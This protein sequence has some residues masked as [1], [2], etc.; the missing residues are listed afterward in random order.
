V[1]EQ[2]PNRKFVA[3]FEVHTYSSLNPT[4]MQRYQGT[5]NPADA[6]CVLYDPHVFELKRMEV[7][8]K[9]TIEQRFG[10]GEALSDLPL[11]QAWLSGA[12]QADQPLVVLLMSSGNLCGLSMDYFTDS[13]RS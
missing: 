7:P 5:L 3:V 2:Y 10:K 13:K 9:E 11:L 6:V 1:R 4:F 8:S 12:M